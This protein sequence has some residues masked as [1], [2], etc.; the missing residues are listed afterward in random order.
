MRHYLIVTCQDYRDAFMLPT[1]GGLIALARAFA[2]P[3]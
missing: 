1:I 2:G 3:A